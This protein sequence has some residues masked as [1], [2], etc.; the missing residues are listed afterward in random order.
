M[1]CGRWDA[2]RYEN[3]NQKQS[4]STRWQVKYPCLNSRK[5]DTIST[6]LKN[7][8]FS[9]RKT[10]SN[11]FNII[12]SGIRYTYSIAS[13]ALDPK[14]NQKKNQTFSEMMLNYLF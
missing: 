4:K 12:A 14:V 11:V 10:I 13:V 3:K 8:F 7:S 2:M 6:A 5:R 1:K 9:F